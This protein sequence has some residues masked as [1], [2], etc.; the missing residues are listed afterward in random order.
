MLG[1]MS[2][3]QTERNRLAELLLE[4][5]PDAPTLCEGWT[6]RDLATHLFIRERK[7]LA[8][9]G[10]FVR[11]A[12]RFLEAEEARL[13]SWSYEDLV[14]MWAVG[15]PTLFMPSDQTLNTAEHFIHHEDVRRGD[16]VIEPRQFS[17]VINREL[18]RLAKRFGSATLKKVSV[19]VI[20]TPPDLPPV[21]IGERVGVSE[22]G[23]NVVRVY[24]EP[25]ELLLWA[26]GRRAVKVKVTGAV[27]A[28]SGMDIKL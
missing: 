6:T 14:R 4:V 20:L 7:P 8:A 23:D 17:K 15:P 12:K 13:A 25:G 24:G 26:A 18:L 5:G 10:I 1:P 19:P 21:V 9:I 28:L 11:R 16:G 2:F 27:E 3:A 22:Q